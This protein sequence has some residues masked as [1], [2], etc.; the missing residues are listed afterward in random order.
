MDQSNQLL[1]D[2]H[3]VANVMRLTAATATVLLSLQ[4]ENKFDFC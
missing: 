4:N 3:P 1:R 2:I